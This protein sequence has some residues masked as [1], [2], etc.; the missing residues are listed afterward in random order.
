MEEIDMKTMRLAAV[1]AAAAFA[2]L[3]LGAAPA[4]ANDQPLVSVGGNAC[5]A[6][7]NWNGP[8]NILN[9]D[10]TVDYKACNHNNNGSNPGVVDVLDNACV[11][12]WLWNGPL[13]IANDSPST[14]Y[15][16]CAHN[17]S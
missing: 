15:K 7:W 17:V 3:A 6:P 16:V 11:A 12:P 2:G 9:N 5:V 1:V 10:E 8:G 4:T 14:S 13:N